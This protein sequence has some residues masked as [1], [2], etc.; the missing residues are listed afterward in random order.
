MDAFENMDFQHWVDNLDDDDIDYF[1]NLMMNGQLDDV[2]D[3]FRYDMEYDDYDEYDDYSDDYGY[4]SFYKQMAGTVSSGDTAPSRTRTQLSPALTQKDLHDMSQVCEKE[5]KEYCNDP[6]DSNEECCPVFKDDGYQQRF[7]RKAAFRPNPLKSTKHL[8]T[9]QAKCLV[10]GE[11]CDISKPD[12][13]CSGLCKHFAGLI[14]SYLLDLFQHLHFTKV[15]SEFM[16][17]A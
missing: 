4:D 8:P 17:L 5:D 14:T 11:K 13:C 12:E 7:C 1:Y 16:A 15:A 3:A 10:T 2:M 9:C 6:H